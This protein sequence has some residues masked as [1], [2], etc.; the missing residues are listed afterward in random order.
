VFD[1]GHALFD[2]V[3][4]YG[5]EAIVA[6][7]VRL[8][9]AVEDYHDSVERLMREHGS[10]WRTSSAARSA[11]R[12]YRRDQPRFRYPLPQAPCC[13]AP[14]ARHFFARIVARVR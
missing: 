7:L 12:R 5:L 9:G 8:T 2:A 13:T 10:C 6:H 4:S 11:A 14:E 3:V 1:D